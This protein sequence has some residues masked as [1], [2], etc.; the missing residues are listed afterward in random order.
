MQGH[1]LDRTRSLVERHQI[2]QLYL[3]SMQ[4]RFRHIWAI[5][6]IYIIDDELSETNITMIDTW[7]LRIMVY[8]VDVCMCACVE[9]PCEITTH[10]RRCRWQKG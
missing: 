4:H 9:C 6:M 10:Q 5:Y 3:A 2:Q 7:E 1:R 8:E